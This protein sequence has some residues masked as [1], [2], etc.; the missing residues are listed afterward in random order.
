MRLKFIYLALIPT[1]IFFAG[2]IIASADNNLAPTATLNSSTPTPTPIFNSEIKEIKI[3][4]AIVATLKNDDFD[5]PAFSPDGT[6]LAYTKESTSH[7]EIY[8]YDLKTRKISVLLTAKQSQ[9]YLP[10]GSQVHILNWNGANRLY[11]YLSDGDVCGANLTFNAQTRTIIKVEEECYDEDKVDVFPKTLVPTYDLFIKSFPEISPEAV[12]FALQ[13]DKSYK[14]GNGMIAQFKF[15]EMDSN[16]W[17]FDFRTKKKQL[18][19]KAPEDAGMDFNLIGITEIGGNALLSI[20]YKDKTTFFTFQNGK[21][22]EVLQTGYIGYFQMLYK[23]AQKSIF[24][25]R[26]KD[27]DSPIDASV[28]VFDGKNLKLATDLKGVRNADID[29]TGSKIAYSFQENEM[30]RNIV[31]KKLENIF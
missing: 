8:I 10:D 18:L 28:W 31:I 30:R 15:A 1:F 23:S 11:A 9:K 20:E 24:I 3:S 2:G 5:S 14:F 6:K 7:A 29:K 25:L 13:S 22:T 19:V 17:Y 26:R 27:F 12:K 16:V 21:V 4:G